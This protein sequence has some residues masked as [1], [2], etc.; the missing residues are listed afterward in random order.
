MLLHSETSAISIENDIKSCF[1]FDNDV[2]LNISTA[3]H[4]SVNSLKG[5]DNHNIKSPIDFN[6]GRPNANSTMIHFGTTN[7]RS[8]PWRPNWRNIKQNPHFVSVKS[9]GMPRLDQKPVLNHTLVTEFESHCSKTFKNENEWTVQKLPIQQSILDFVEVTFQTEND[10]GVQNNFEN[11]LFKSPTKTIKKKKGQQEIEWTR[12]KLLGNKENIISSTP[13]KRKVLVDISNSL[14]KQV[15][16]ETRAENN[17]VFGFDNGSIGINTNTSAET[18]IHWHTGLENDNDQM[19]SDDSKN[20]PKPSR[21]DLTVLK[22]YLV[23]D[24]K[25]KK[26]IISDKVVQA[27]NENISLVQT[28]NPDNSKIHLFE[29]PEEILDN[30]SPP[31]LARKSHRRKRLDSCDSN[32]ENCEQKRKRHKKTK[33]EIQQ[34]EWISNFNQMCKEI[35]QHELELD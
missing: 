1:G 8:S 23:K 22:N 16:V 3:N 20:R 29:E 5:Q 34:E 13:V 31:Q 32:P 25:K 4:S 17:T 2:P 10:Y 30:M 21:F 6:M 7:E 33:I 27:P 18:G 35:D 11:E 9:N 19:F 26:V 12:K 28:S 24:R 15:F 14:K